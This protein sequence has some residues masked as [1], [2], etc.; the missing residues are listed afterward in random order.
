MKAVIVDIDGTLSD[1][2]HR[3]Q[4][5]LTRPKDFGRWNAAMHM[6]KPNMPV[7]EVVRLLSRENKLLL[8]T[9]REESYRDITNK[10]LANVADV[11]FH[12][13][14]M[15]ADK[16]YRNDDIIKSEIY[17][18]ILVDGFKPWLAVDDRNRVVKMFRDRGLTVFQVADGDF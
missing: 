13:M 1:P 12:K 4:F 14:Y 9:G 3:R 7:I 15:R 16:D 11:W 17:D 5:V 18:Q 10:W 8:V 2:T 6:D